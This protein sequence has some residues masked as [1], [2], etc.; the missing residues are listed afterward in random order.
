MFVQRLSTFVFICLTS[1][2]TASAW[3]QEQSGTVQ[4]DTQ[5]SAPDVP[6]VPTPQEVVDEMLRLANVS[7]EDVLYDLGSGD[8]RIVISAAQQFGAR[9]IGVDINPKRISEAQENALKAGV[10]DR[11]QFL[12]QDLFETDFREATVVTLYLLP[13]VN[14][15][16]RPLL[17]RD[18]KPGT[19][20]VSHE[21]DMGDWRADRE[22][23]LAG[24]YKV[25]FWVI[26]AQVAGTWTWNPDGASD[27]QPYELHLT[28]HFQQVNGFLK[29]N[30]IEMPV[31]NVKLVG[32][33]LD[34]L[35]LQETAILTFS[36]RV[37]DQRI[38]GQV[39]IDD[40][41]TKSRQPWVASRTVAQ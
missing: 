13:K 9:G 3:M 28:Q 18:L 14:L 25:Y 7:R 17:L 31:A 41:E 2:C 34:F 36:G 1:A 16:L 24:G 21:F 4:V 37:N 19:R 32:E 33:Q 15:R 11:V 20:V 6:Y 23:H 12:Q 40:G 29:A 5:A 38:T 39:E 8:G 30:G 27:A 10:T 26:P 22:V 35:A